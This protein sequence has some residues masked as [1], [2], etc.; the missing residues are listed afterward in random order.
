MLSEE[1]RS[2][3]VTDGY[4]FRFRKHLK[5]DVDRYCFTKKTCTA[6]IHL[7]NNVIIVL[8]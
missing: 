7:N 8:L 5:N 3:Y 6:Y 2:L 4:R 1:N